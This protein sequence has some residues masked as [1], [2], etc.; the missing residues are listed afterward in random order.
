MT[1]R[2]RVL[3]AISHRQP[4]KTPYMITFTQK[5]RHAMT[6]YCGDDA[7]TREIDNCFHMV[8]ALPGGRARWVNA[9]VWEDEF[10]VRWDKSLDKD[11]GNVCNA[12]VSSRSLDGI[13]FPNPAGP[14]RFDWLANACTE[15]AGRFVSF[16]IGFSL[17]ERAWLLRGGIAE[18]LVDMLEAP[19]F[20]DDLLDRICDYNMALISQ[21][22]KY[23]IDG[24]HFGDDWGMQ[25][26]LLM[27]PRLWERFLMPRLARQYAA[28]KQQGN[29]VSIHCCGKIDELLPRLIEIG[30]DCFNPFQPEVMD[31]YAL[32][33]QFRGRLAF[34]GGLSTQRLLP[35][36]SPAEVR[37]EVRRLVAEVGEGGG[38]ILGPAHDIPGDARPENVLA[39]IDAANGN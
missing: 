39:M 32:K 14:G 26:G 1:N 24:I 36:G 28:A 3:A 37:R 7:F 31:V 25:Q 35:Y 11:I 19:G 29:A 21:A 2:E 22:C 33:H 30:V 8:Y 17:F 10:G 9:D 16:N 27:S 23:P 13:A 5:A 38:F 20:V 18:F 4:D 34:W 12:V 15:A 6:A